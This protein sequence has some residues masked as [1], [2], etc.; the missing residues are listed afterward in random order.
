MALSRPIVK[1]RAARL[2]LS[3]C[4]LRVFVVK[5]LIAMDAKSQNDGLFFSLIV[6]PFLCTFPEILFIDLTYARDYNESNGINFSGVS[7]INRP[8]I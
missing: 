8:I 7:G 5:S 4:A 1:G 2:A 3:L 6:C